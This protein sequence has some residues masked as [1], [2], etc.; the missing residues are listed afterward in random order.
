MPDNR[1]STVQYNYIVVSLYQRDEN[2]LHV[3]TIVV[4]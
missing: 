2:N 3:Y 1:G 4:T